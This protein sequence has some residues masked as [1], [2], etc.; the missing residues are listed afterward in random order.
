MNHAHNSGQAKVEAASFLLES[1][2]FARADLLRAE[3]ERQMSG[4]LEENDGLTPFTYA[5]AR[6]AYQFLSACAEH[7]FSEGLLQPLIS[8]LQ[9]WS[10][11]SLG[12]SHV[13]TPHA[14][15]YINGCSRE[16]LSDTVSA[17][18]HYMLSLG[19]HRTG[20]TGCI[21]LV[22][23]NAETQDR[24]MAVDRVYNMQLEFNQLLAHSTANAY[25]VEPVKSSMN[26]AEGVLLL[27]GYLW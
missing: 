21:K 20:K 2:F 7:L 27:D 16:L 6:G 14:R 22:T 18:W 26:P 15:V 9:A 11:E 17:P 23:G 10:K 12:L 13:S 25:A 19:V 8:R 3:F 5:F 1:S 4:P 24:T